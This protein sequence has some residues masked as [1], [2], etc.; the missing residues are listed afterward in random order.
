MF[1]HLPGLADAN[2]N[3]ALH[4][5]YRE[6]L[7]ELRAD[8]EA[9]YVRLS[10]DGIAVGTAPPA[11]APDIVLRAGA[12]AW[13]ALLSPAPRPGF[14]ALSTMRRTGHLEVGG[15]LLA[16]HQ[17]LLLLEMLFALS[18]RP[19]QAAPAPVGSPRI[20][21][22]SGRYLQLDFEGRPH[23]IYFEEAGQGVPL[24]CLHTAGADGRQFRAVL[25]DDAVTRNFRVIA[26]DLPWHGKSSPPA[27]FETEVYRL[28]T[29]RYVGIVMAVKD[30]LGLD[31]PVVMGCSIGG[32][33]VL[34]LALRHG[35]AFRAAVG[36]QS[37]L[38]AENQTGNEE[39]QSRMVMHRPDVHG[40]KFAG[41]LMAGVMA[42]QSPA[43]ERWETMWHYMQGGP[44]VFLGDLH[45][46]FVD[47][48]LRN[49]MAAGIDTQ[50]CPV[51]LLSGEYDPS[52]TPEMGR[53]LAEEIGAT[54]FEVMR[55]M[56]HFPMSEN[57]ERFRQYLLPVLEKILAQD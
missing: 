39:P 35:E 7:L 51:Y 13:R 40:G 31:Q 2:P 18:R 41:A 38:Y 34:H 55:D 8:G 50:K 25:N 29:D 24:L 37:A 20:E 45:Y 48:D 9:E 5:G 43:S 49:G 12:E 21:P 10:A 6:L 22:V 3:I 16:Y 1:E 46:Y 26:F 47:G 14:Q 54:H 23:R 42:P 32:R 36:L 15:D 19:A 11:K 53:A 27:G 33:V 30:A 28:T 52:A 57:P 4:C 17:N 56:G 44:G